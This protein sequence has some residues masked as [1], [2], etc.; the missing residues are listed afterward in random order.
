MAG[1]SSAKGFLGSDG[2][3]RQQ[4]GGTGFALY[5]VR[6]LRQ[7]VGAP[8]SLLGGGF[9]PFGELHDRFRTHGPALLV[10]LV[11]AVGR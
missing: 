8:P 11:W 3:V 10:A 6:C 4:S 2:P 5:R 7:W 9:V 1:R